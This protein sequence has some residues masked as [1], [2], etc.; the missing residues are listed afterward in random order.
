[1]VKNTSVPE[2]VLSKKHNAINFHAVREA[3]A[4]GVLE[5]H[6]EV[7]QSNLAHVFTKV[8]PPAGDRCRELLASMHPLQFLM[9][10]QG[11]PPVSDI[12]TSCATMLWTYEQAYV[13]FES[14]GLFQ[15]TSR[16]GDHT[17]VVSYCMMMVLTTSVAR[18]E[19]DSQHPNMH[20]V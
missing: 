9:Y 12:G 16:T 3:V 6:K 17:T 13:M 10:A 15:T 4:A 7:M 20:I 18:P 14:R 11:F 5:V 8:L 1:M 2:S 19:V